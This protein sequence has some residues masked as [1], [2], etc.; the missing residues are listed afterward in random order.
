ML[1]R[2]T[3]FL[4]GL[5]GAPGRYKR[6]IKLLVGVATIVGPVLLALR[7]FAHGAIQC[8]ALD[9]CAEIMPYLLDHTLVKI[10]ISLFPLLTIATALL[11]FIPSKD[12]NGRVGL[13][14]MYVVKVVV[15]SSIAYAVGTFFWEFLQH[16]QITRLIIVVFI[17]DTFGEIAMLFWKT[18]ASV[19]NAFAAG[20]SLSRRYS[21]FAKSIC[22]LVT[23]GFVTLVITSDWSHPVSLT[24]QFTRWVAAHSLGDII[25][26][27]V[28][29][30]LNVGVMMY[31]VVFVHALWTG[32]TF[33]IPLTLI[34]LFV[35]LGAKR[36]WPFGFAAWIVLVAYCVSEYRRRKRK[37]PAV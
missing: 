14:C 1:E 5:F 33:V 18:L 6:L 23:L 36:L 22:G 2:L 20:R 16:H 26:T 3:A 12:E 9:H 32:E 8:L 31:A 7:F 17:W 35:A 24:L 29:L 34:P 11:M 30:F 25:E 4:M 19:P 28:H 15:A 21:F 10:G 27:S 37:Q 13:G